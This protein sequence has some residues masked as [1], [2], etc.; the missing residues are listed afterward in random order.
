MHKFLW[1]WREKGKKRWSKAEINTRC[2]WLQLDPAYPIH[3]HSQLQ[4]QI[5]PLGVTAAQPRHGLIIT[6]RATAAVRRAPK[7]WHGRRKHVVSGLMRQAQGEAVSLRNFSE[8]FTCNLSKTSPEGVLVHQVWLVGR[9]WAVIL[10]RILPMLMNVSYAV[11]APVINRKNHDG[12]TWTLHKPHDAACT[13]ESVMNKQ[14]DHVTFSCVTFNTRTYLGVWSS[15][16]RALHLMSVFMRTN[17]FPSCAHRWLVLIIWGRSTLRPSH[18]WAT[19]R[20]FTPNQP[21]RLLI[22]KS[23]DTPIPSNMV[24]NVVPVTKI[25]HP[26][27]TSTTSMPNPGMYSHLSIIRHTNRWHFLPTPLPPQRHTHTVDPQISA[28]RTLPPS[29][30]SL[31]FIPPMLLPLPHC[32]S[33]RV[34]LAAASYSAGTKWS[35][36]RE[37]ERERESQR[38]ALPKARQSG[39]ADSPPFY[40]SSALIFFKSSSSVLPAKLAMRGR[41]VK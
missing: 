24:S 12:C 30:T 22:M 9:P 5:P 37:R 31:P 20:Y 29:Y 1:H 6:V 19:S 41:L 13:V 11:S 35:L 7:W 36:L 25:Q 23:R 33:L 2:C 16:S 4:S 17:R 18:C 10:N 38:L 34:I 28:M 8:S 40:I 21:P 32:I 3:S 26:H 27:S 15:Q 39:P 14:Q